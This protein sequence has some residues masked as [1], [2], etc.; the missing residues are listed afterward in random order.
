MSWVLDVL[1]LY[2]IK[3]QCNDYVIVAD[4][5]YIHLCQIGNHPNLIVGVFDSL[6]EKLKHETSGKVTL[7]ILY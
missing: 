6:K 3:P 4:G 1:E 2:A 5:G 7:K